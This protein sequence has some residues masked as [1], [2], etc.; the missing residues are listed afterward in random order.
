[1]Y[2]V[3]YCKK[4]C[5]TLLATLFTVF[6][7]FFFYSAKNATLGVYQHLFYWCSK[8]LI[9]HWLH[10]RL[11]KMSQIHIVSS[12]NLNDYWPITL[13]SVVMKWENFLLLFMHAQQYPQ[14]FQFQSATWLSR[15]IILSAL[16]P[17]TS[18]QEK[19]RM[20]GCCLLATVQQPFHLI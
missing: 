11:I 14:Y 3:L 12:S 9:K 7:F 5:S 20:S 15:W 18:G 8:K 1:M 10:L 6:F 2:T 4:N 17:E 13:T 19:H 16:G